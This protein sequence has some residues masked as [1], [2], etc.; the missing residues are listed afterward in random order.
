MPIP[1]GFDHGALVPPLQ[2]AGGD[3]C[4]RNDFSRCKA[5]RHES[6]KT[7]ETSNV[8]NVSDILGIGAV[9]QIAKTERVSD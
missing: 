9:D 4:Q 7:F 1:G 8:Q 5:I 6:P 3:A 2:L